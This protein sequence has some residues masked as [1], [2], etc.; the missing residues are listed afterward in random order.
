MNN[1]IIISACIDKILF[2]LRGGKIINQSELKSTAGEYNLK[3]NDI[4]EL[5]LKLTRLGITIMNE[6][7]SGVD[8]L[9]DKYLI[10]EWDTSGDRDV[11]VQHYPWNTYSDKD[12]KKI[13]KQG[14]KNGSPSKEIK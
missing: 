8:Q 2:D 11:Y 5:E 4:P 12:K 3:D 9:L 13:P 14:K 6:E 7:R 1:D 10:R